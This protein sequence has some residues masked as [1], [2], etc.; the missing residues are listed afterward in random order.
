MQ[1]KCSISI[2]LIIPIYNE[3]ALVKAAVE[4]CLQQL[5]HDFIDYELIL[6]DDGSRDT[7]ASILKAHFSNHNRVVFLPNMINLNQG[8]SV[9][10]GYAVAKKTFAVH[11]GIDLPLSIV[12]L[13]VL[14]EDI[15]DADVMVLQRKQYSGATSWRLVTSNVNI[16]IRTLMFPILSRNLKDMN[17]TQIYRMD[18]VQNIMPLAKSPAFTTPEMIFR[19]KDA[20]LKIKIKDV[21]FHA[22]THGSGSLGKLHDILWTIYDMLRFRYLMW[23]G[24]DKHG[25]VK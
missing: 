24:L 15:G 10:R 17:F 4:N 9:Q 12:E 8:V 19:A 13:R 14:V 16:L 22:R 1:S 20:G 21:Q 6:I 2:S 25:K 7:T 11:N 18:Q 3:E 5:E 23:I